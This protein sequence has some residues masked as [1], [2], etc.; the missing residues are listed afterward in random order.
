MP[1]APSSRLRAYLSL[2]RPHQWIK[3]GFV[4]LP[5][6]FGHRLHDQE[7]IVGSVAGFLV[8]CLASSAVY[9]LNDSV[10]FEADRLHP[11]KKRRPV[12][13]GLISKSGARRFAA[14]LGS[15]ALVLGYL[16]STRMFILT[17]SGYIVLN[18]LY[19]FW[20][21]H[22]ALVDVICIAAGF[23]L[24]VIAG[25]VAIGV[26]L[27]QWLIL[28]T[29]LLATFLAIAKRRDDII[30]TANGAGVQ[31]RS[32]LAGYSQ[33]YISMSMVFLASISVVSYILYTVS[34]DVV[35]L[36]NSER[37]YLTSI[38]VV[39]GFLRYFQN[40][41]VFENGG[42]PTHIVLRDRFLQVT[43]VAWLLTLYMLIY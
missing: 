1:Q 43:I 12:A 15:L 22:Y 30:L 26:Q 2:A 35:R 10:D 39:I 32:S 29:F 17:L 27:S 5:L 19:S 4:L 14:L 24:R 11:I 31:I 23:L 13:N 9:S 36:H 41:F 37:L 28:M 7:A 34:P 18:I 38:F 8:F 20:L 21:K 42:S 6:F 33:E 3:N 40:V 16:L 25:G